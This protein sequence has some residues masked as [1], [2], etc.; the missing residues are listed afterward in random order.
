MP[1]NYTLYPAQIDTALN[2]PPVVDM[3][4][5][6][7][8]AVTNGLRGAIL[9]IEAT[10]GVQPNGPSSTV[11]G[12]LLNIEGAIANIKAVQLGQ[13]LGGTLIAPKVIGIQGKP[14]STAS[15][16]AGQVL[17]WN[18]IAWVPANVMTGSTTAFSGDLSGNPIAQ[19]VIGIQ[20]TPVSTTAPTTG[21]ILSFNG[22]QWVPAGFTL[23]G[24]AG[25][26]LSGTYPN[27]TVSGLE[28]KILPV[29][30]TGYLNY[31][32]SAWALTSIPSSFP[33]SGTA[34][35]DLSG[36]YPNPLVATSNGHTIIT[37]VTAAGGD[38]TGTYPN[39]TV[40]KLQGTITLSSTPTTG[41]VL[42]ATS[43]IAANWQTPTVVTSVTMGGDVTGNSAT[44]SVIRINGA[45]VPV[46]GSLTTGNT[47]QVS[48]ASTLSYAPVNLAG[49]ANFVTGALPISSG[50]TG[51]TAGLP[52]G[53][54]GTGADGTATC[55]GSTI[56]TGMTSNGTAASVTSVSGGAAT[57]TGLINVNPDMIGNSI[58]FSG[59]SSGGNNGTFVVASWISS[60]SV[61][62][63]N[64]SAVSN[65]AHNG[66]I[67]WHALNYYA[68]ARDIDFFSLTINSGVNVNTNGYRVFGQN[69]IVN[70]L[71][72]ANGYLGF[73]EGNSIPCPG[74]GG[75]PNINALLAGGGHAWGGEDASPSINPGL[76]GQGG[77]GGTVAG[78]PGTVTPPSASTYASVFNI[79][80]AITMITYKVS[81]GSVSFT[82]VGG[83]T[84]GSLGGG[85]IGPSGGSGGGMMVLI[86]QTLSGSG[87]VSA[88]G[89]QG[90]ISAGQGAGGGGGG[91]VI[92]FV[93]RTN[94]LTSAL[95]V[96][97]GAAGTGTGGGQLPQP[98]SPGTI[99]QFHA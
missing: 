60:S 23:T 34:G 53:I 84:G 12:R 16:A 88:N 85:G 91:G 6:V 78:S 54:F 98:G 29:L 89:G 11:A 74:G 35:G 27:P 37:S 36:T 47:L 70:G 49:G 86:V 24:P 97:G 22:A 17:A 51:G 59:A 73:P 14:I 13:D 87:T 15:P 62:V 25:G 20:G 44:S 8:G 10:L 40:A 67:S 76:G 56:I 48:G 55:D 33:P 81:S 90:G 26:D 72:H 69:L 32:G 63:T 3:L 7:Q 21:Q 52:D 82:A 58:T 64:A 99:I 42:T 80:I 95:T 28:G 57:I 46:S 39:P 92:V 93:N 66:S 68:L 75:A 9:S 1:T 41:Q 30:S 83:G 45:T 38:L 71:L 18:G 79:S 94:N 77:V 5:P 31:T 65:D 96:N 19:T 43:A 4:T 2:L 50:G 61:T